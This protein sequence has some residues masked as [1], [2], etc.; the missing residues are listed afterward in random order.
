MENM[1]FNVPWWIWMIL[2][3]I[4]AMIIFNDTARGIALNVLRG[5]VTGSHARKTR[6]KRKGR[7]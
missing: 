4:L 1:S 7:K 5:Q 6:K 2:G 3:Y